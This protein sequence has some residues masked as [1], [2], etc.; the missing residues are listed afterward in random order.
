MDD[1]FIKI[2][3]TDA[4][5]SPRVKVERTFFNFEAARTGCQGKEFHRVVTTSYIQ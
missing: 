3:I 4:V 1:D 5:P 2:I